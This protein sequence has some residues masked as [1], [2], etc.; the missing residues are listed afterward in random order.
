MDNSNTLMFKIGIADVKAELD[1]HKKEIDSWV[2]ANPIKLKVQ[3]ED[4][5]LDQLAAKLKAMGATFGESNAEVNKLQEEL[6][7]LKA[8]LN[9]ILNGAGTKESA[10][11]NE[12]RVMTKSTESAVVAMNQL[13]KL[14]DETAGKTGKSFPVLDRVPAM[15]S[16]LLFDIE[17][18]M[19][20]IGNIMSKGNLPSWLD[21]GKGR[22]YINNVFSDYERLLKTMQ[23]FKE[24]GFI[25]FHNVVALRD[26]FKGLESAYG[27]ILKQASDYNKQV[28]LNAKAEEK[29]INQNLKAEEKAGAARVAAREKQE[30]EYERVWQNGLKAREKA[31]EKAINQKQKAEEKAATLQQKFDAA[32]QKMY[33]D[34]GLRQND[35]GL[36]N[37]SQ[38]MDAILP[39]ISKVRED[40]D[41]LKTSINAGS[42]EGIPFINE[43]IQ[44]L[45]TEADALMRQYLALAEARDRLMAGGNERSLLSTEKQNKELEMLNETFRK[46]TS[47]LQK[48]A[49]AEDEAQK[50]AEKAAIKAKKT[51]DNLRSLTDRLDAKK[52]NF[53]GMDLSEF[54]KAIN[55]IRAIKAELENFSKTGSSSWGNTAK[56]IVHNMGLAT[57]KEEASVALSRLTSQKRNAKNANIE[58]SDS[59]QK[60]AKSIKE[61]TDSVRSQSQVM[62]DL[63]MLAMQ[64]LSVWGAQSFINNIIETGGLL[65]QQR[66]SLSAILGD[67]GKATTLFD[68]IK[69]LALKSPFG[70]VELDKMSKQLAAYSFEY[71]ELFDWTK[72][73]AD[74]SAATGTSVDRL[75]LALGHVRSE[76]AL[77]GYTL[78]QFAMANVP[79]LKMLSQNLGISSKEVRERVRK[80]DISADDVQD[81]LKQLTDDGGMFANAQEIMS[82]ALNAKFKNLRDAFDIMYGEIAEGGVGDAL[83]DLAVILTQGAKHWER[84]SKDVLMVAAA[85]GVGKGAILLYNK[86]IGE[87]TAATLKS[88]AVGKRQMVDNL[89]IAATYRKLTTEEEFDIATK[90]KLNSRNIMVA[91][92]S[93]KLTIEELK[94][95]V[96]MRKVSKEDAIAAM[97]LLKLNTAGMAEVTVLKRRQIAWIMLGNAMKIAGRSLLAIGKAFLPLAALTAVFEILN[98]RSEQKD[99][100]KDFASSMAGNARG[101]EA[102]ELRGT[103][104]DSKKLN[105]E[106]LRSNIE[107]MKNALEVAGAYTDQLKKQ[108]EQT[109]DLTVKYNLLKDKIGEVADKY[110]ELK[111]SQEKM[112]KDAWDAGGGL[113][114]DNMVKDAEQYDEAFAQYQ[115]TLTVGSKQIKDA[116]QNWMQ[117]HGLYKEEYANMTG[118]QMFEQLSKENQNSFLLYGW[119]AK[120]ID[121]KTKEVIRNISRA[122]N[123]VA[124]NLNELKGSQG[125]EF[126]GTMKAIYEEAFGVDLDHA[127]Q[128]QVNAFDKW[129]RETIGRADKLSK[130]AKEALRGIVIDFTVT[131]KP[132]YVVEQ[133]QTAQDVINSQIGDN[134]WLSSFFGRQNSNTNVWTVETAQKEVGKYKKLFG[135]ISLSNLDTAP[136]KLNTLLDGLEKTKENLQNTL[137][138]G[139]LSKEERDSI[140]NSLNETTNSIELADKALKDVGGKRKK[141]GDKSKGNKED[142]NAKAVRE[143]IRVLKEVADAYQYWRDKVG[144]QGAWIHVQEEFGSLLNELKLNAKNVNDLRGNLKNLDPQINKIKDAKIKT[145]TKK[146]RDKELAQLS[147]KDFEKSTEDWASKLSR[148]LDELTRKWEIF[149]SVVSD[150]GDRMLASRISGISPGATPADL[151]RMAVRSTAGVRIDFD[152]VLGMSD[153]EIDR[154]VESLGVAEEKIKAVQN[155]LKD[156]KKAEQDVYKSD[157][158]NYAK[159]LGSLVDLESIRMRNQEEY[160]RI[161]EETNRLLSQGVITQEEA[162]RRRNAA[163]T[164]RDTKNWQATSIYTSLYNNSQAM[165]EGEF[166]AAYNREMANLFDQ[167]KAGTITMSD[168]AEKVE[169]LNKIAAE[170]KMQGFLGIKGGAGAYLSGGYQGLIDYHWNKAREKRAAGDIEGADK[171]KET[172]ESMMKA[173]RAAEQ[174]AKAFNDLSSGA[175]L[176][177]NMFDALGMEGAAT[178]FGDAA[179][180]LGGIG[181]GAQSLSALGPWGMAAGGILG[182]ITSIAQLNDKNHERRIQELKREV[183]K[184]DNTLNTIKSLRERELGY[185]RGT[186]RS[187][188]VSLYKAQ[189][190]SISLFGNKMSITPAQSGMVEYYGRY[191]GGNGYSQEY[192]ALVETR[193]KYMEMY[194]EENAKKKKSQ[195]ALEEYKVKIAELDEEIMYFVQD[196]AKDLWSI[197]IQG[198]ASQISD[199]LWTAFENGEDAV[200]AFGDTAKDIVSSVAKNMMTLS[201]IEPMFKQLQYDLFGEW[202][203]SLMRYK[204]NAIQYDSN[205]NI[206]MQASEEP[207]LKVLGRYFGEGGE[208]EKTAEASETFYK[209]VEK[210]TGMDLSSDESKSGASSSIKNI[211]ES[212]ADLL[213]SYLNAVRLDVSVVRAIQGEYF[214]LF[215]QAILASNT[216]LTN[217]E[218]NTAAIMRSNDIIANKIKAI[219]DRFRGLENKTWKMPIA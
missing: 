40:I 144:D 132:N 114:S 65:E 186:L 119:D 198:W 44:F 48:K 174:L 63:K 89:K 95:A 213:A 66:L 166:Y 68:Q 93:K 59:E 62:S 13:S 28:E 154:Y 203:S 208:L 197:D 204:G 191:S 148:D 143:K 129:L 11:T 168:Y 91:L 51:S 126:A 205:G 26:V 150:T 140:N 104:A 107:E 133:P 216:S 36:Q 33:S 38:A 157:I 158:Q 134:K 96:A 113:F 175:D 73:L 146:E 171:E 86:A 77:S 22:G 100:A 83:K 156:W 82:E 190:R 176:V 137:E 162:E 55:K 206:D 45:Q 209:W 188:L 46:G 42:K 194:D 53:N 10:A 101:K 32:R 69:N 17:N 181:Q 123:T 189:E 80:K 149:N 182:G 49:K 124:D 2:N 210:I 117:A 170:F 5:A 81:I 71:E 74:I 155:G 109:D 3:F 108:V 78:R 178:A 25:D 195:E 112:L 151:K 201:V 161:L 7:A 142:Q 16:K 4:S 218:N 92:S 147:R 58:L 111:A 21:D 164:S 1:K 159:W 165:A 214:P 50:A 84:L 120:D 179:G 37:I 106:A 211:T 90:G 187:Q 20:A 116:V 125:E 99:S 9:S 24:Q 54:D 64:Y 122:Y 29:A 102:F 128:E 145:E 173:Q 23:Q 98:R 88:L 19:T 6:A 202:D 47:E 18:R 185:D 72:R 160:N 61:T 217:I 52:I 8:I 118:K 39:K 180:V 15:Y 76:G 177:A 30:K 184:I 167:M 43:N 127:T 138:N 85:Y 183:T 75:A 105:K 212:T 60:L 215:L 196:L 34:M 70:V 14:I 41:Q 219:D 121:D 141:K 152:S 153:E 35:P 97:N 169:K 67:M 12:I 56:D 27:P 110:E 192:N 57:A 207:V 172:A 79:V 87:G 94:R 163:A 199:A 139:L 136:K 130:D 193:K 135:D 103:L 115:K 31:E 131:L 200:K